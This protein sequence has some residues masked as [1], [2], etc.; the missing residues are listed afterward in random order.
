[1][2]NK[3]GLSVTYLL[4]VYFTC[5][6]TKNYSFNYF[7]KQYLSNSSSNIQRTRPEAQ[8]SKI[9]QSGLLHIKFSKP[10]R[11]PEHPEYIQNDTV[12]LN[13]T[14]NLILLFEIV[15]DKFTDPF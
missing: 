3:L 9:E 13:G 14:Y 15:P 11:V 6:V 7:S 5:N 4:D 1:M 10:M 2:S 8:I 12:N